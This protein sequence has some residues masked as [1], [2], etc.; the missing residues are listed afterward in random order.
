MTKEYCTDD[1]F[2]LIY[3]GKMIHFAGKHVGCIS[4]NSAT[5][6]C[7]YTA[8]EMVDRVA[9]LDLDYGM[10]DLIRFSELDCTIPIE[11]TDSINTFNSTGEF[12]PHITEVI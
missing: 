2:D 12:T 1:R 8:Q 7:F 9:E 4:S 3:L 5:F 11:W 10:Y 6:E